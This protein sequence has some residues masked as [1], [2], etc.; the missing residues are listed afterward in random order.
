MVV[1]TPWIAKYIYYFRFKP[2]CK[3]GT[4]ILEEKQDHE[5]KIL[6]GVVKEV[7]GILYATNL[8]I[9]REGC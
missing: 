6:C 9:S 4:T 7:F 3:N 2:M 5:V 8:I 1:Y